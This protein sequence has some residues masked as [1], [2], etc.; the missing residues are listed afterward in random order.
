MRGIA[1]TLTEDHMKQ[2]AD[3]YAGTKAEGAS[4]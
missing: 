2:L 4:K 1:A 3:F